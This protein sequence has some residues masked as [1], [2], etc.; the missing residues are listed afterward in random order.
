MCTDK[1]MSLIGRSHCTQMRQTKRVSTIPRAEAT[2][3][4]QT[5]GLQK[6]TAM[7][8]SFGGG[9]ATPTAAPA[10]ASKELAIPDIYSIFPHLKLA[11][12]IEQCGIADTTKIQSQAASILDALVHT[13]SAAQAPDNN[14]RNQLLSI[15]LKVNG[16]TARLNHN[17][18]GDVV[19]IADT[20]HI[21]EATAIGLYHSAGCSY[22]EGSVKEAAVRLYWKCRMKQVR[23]AKAILLLALH[24]DDNLS[25]IDFLLS[26]NLFQLISRGLQ[27]RRI[28]HHEENLFT[29]EIHAERDVL[30]ETAYFASYHMQ[31]KPHVPNWI[32]AILQHEQLQTLDPFH[33]VTSPDAENWESTWV[34]SAFSTGWP[35][36]LR[37]YSILVAAC[38]CYPNVSIDVSEL[39]FKVIPAISTLPDVV[40]SKVIARDFF[41]TTLASH[42]A[43]TRHQHTDWFAAANLLCSLG[44]SGCFDHEPLVA[45]NSDDPHAIVFAHFT[46]QAL[47]ADKSNHVLQEYKN[48]LDGSPNHSTQSS[49]GNEYYSLHTSYSVNEATTVTQK[50][51]GDAARA[52]VIAHAFHANDLK[53]LLEFALGTPIDRK[54]R[55]V[56]FKSAAGII[57]NGVSASLA[58]RTLAEFHAVPQKAIEATNVQQHYMFFL[59]SDVERACHQEGVRYDASFGMLF[60]IYI[61][62]RETGCEAT[63]GFL[64]LL[65]IIAHY[66]QLPAFYAEYAIFVMDNMKPKTDWDRNKVYAAAMGFL[67]TILVRYDCFSKDFGYDELNNHLIVDSPQV[68]GTRHVDFP[69]LRQGVFTQ[70]DTEGSGPSAGFSVL[71]SMLCRNRC[72]LLQQVVNVLTQ[73]HGDTVSSFVR[74]T[75]TKALY[76]DT[77]PS[78]TTAR[79]GATGIVS[80]HQRKTYCEKEKNNVVFFS[81]ENLQMK[82]IQAALTLLCATLIRE[83]E[84]KR[85]VHSG[86]RAMS[87][88][89]TLKTLPA[90]PIVD[91]TVYLSE[92]L[93]ILFGEASPWSSLIEQ[94]GVQTGDPGVEAQVS[95]MATAALWGLIEKLPLPQL[96]QVL[97]TQVDNGQGGTK[98]AKSVTIRL[99]SY[100]FRSLTTEDVCYLSFLTRCVLVDLRSGSK[101]MATSLFGSS[102]QVMETLVFLAESDEVLFGDHTANVAA[103]CFEIIYLLTKLGGA[104][105]VSAHRSSW[106]RTR[107]FWNMNLKKILHQNAAVSHAHSVSW[108]LKSF[109]N[110]LSLV[111]GAASGLSVSNEDQQLLAS[112]PSFYN[113]YVS[114]LMMEHDCYMVEALQLLCSGET[115]VDAPSFGSNKELMSALSDATEESLGP[116]GLGCESIIN[117]KLLREIL[118][119][120]SELNEVEKWAISWN[121]FV[122]LEGAKVHLADAMWTVMGSVAL[123]SLYSIPASTK[124]AVSG[125]ARVFSTFVKMLSQRETS[126]P[127][128]RTLTKIVFTAS[129]ILS[130]AGVDEDFA[131]EGMRY[132]IHA[133]GATGNRS[134][135]DSIA[136]EK[137][138]LLGSAL[139]LLSKSCTESPFLLDETV[140]PIFCEAFHILLKASLIDSEASSS[141]RK[142][143]CATIRLLKDGTDPMNLSSLLKEEFTEETTTA[144]TLLCNDEATLLLFAEVCS[145]P[146]ITSYLVDRGVLVALRE[147][148]MNHT[149]LEE[150]QISDQKHKLTIA[151]SSVQVPRNLKA[152]LSCMSTFMATADLEEYNKEGEIRTIASEILVCYKHIFE[153][154][155][156]EFPRNGSAGLLFGF[157][158]YVFQ[159]QKKSFPT[160]RKAELTEIVKAIAETSLRISQ[161]LLP[162]GEQITYNGQGWWGDLNDENLTRQPLSKA[163][164]ETAV[165]AAELSAVGVSLFNGLSKDCRIY[166]GHDELWE[167][168]CRSFD[169]VAVSVIISMRPTQMLNISHSCFRMYSL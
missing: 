123:T 25:A 3:E 163:V 80:N 87:Y 72:S 113:R 32:D 74:L 139:I 107:D 141:T 143:L 162:F 155:V 156:A 85:K 158:Q 39:R 30:A 11:E 128:S 101:V 46:Q 117:R 97:H 43:G 150:Q 77:S 140:Y 48:Q 144:L 145:V 9:T 138:A 126:S 82:A 22:H 49:Y 75:L 64:E 55:G 160:R 105:A 133:M 63:V 66:I 124:L 54:V 67:Q 5:L 102:S 59:P 58:L 100:L 92:N 35:Q 84:F 26:E 62:E 65:T 6:T 130:Q 116:G 109:A 44:F 37:T 161:N 153:H 1:D 8:F 106:L 95:S 99:T 169:A 57:Q 47:A 29:E 94:I 28:K 38:A 104:T 50:T 12:D 24:Q 20:L 142:V 122:R 45:S 154:V 134:A 81:A 79:L 10:A 40:E 71:A 78:P 132:L 127:V 7:A 89:Q 31:Q 114:D 168:I 112:Q 119:E 60:S 135:S 33:Q 157:A 15:D 148:A 70:N 166:V 21:P 2:V 98:L 14:L 17:M 120:T 136:Y 115:Q 152:M 147:M 18:L 137:V 16:Q 108:L 42:L 131:R 51:L 121:E 165:Q 56:L 27:Q 129:G 167:S 149:L 36:Y 86:D 53:L 73:N 164:C 151:T 90:K 34:A 91:G 61:S 4:I 93:V 159:I 110:E 111:G 76:G 41:L 103:Q 23:I 68:E 83:V 88:I 69:Q 96:S 19:Q 146:G 13:P 125:I 118:G 52:S